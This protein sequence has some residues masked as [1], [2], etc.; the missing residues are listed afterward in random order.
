MNLIGTDY[1]FVPRKQLKIIFC[2]PG[3]SFSSN[4][5][6][7]WGELL[8]S[9]QKN[10]IDFQVSPAQDAV[11]YYVRNK[12]LGGEVRRGRNQKPFGGKID[13]DYLMWIDSDIVFRPED[14]YR[15]LKHGKDICAGLYM[16]DGGK[17]FAVVED[18]DT[19]FFKKNG[20]FRFMDADRAKK[21]NGLLEVDYSGF[22]WM[23]IKKGVFESLEY[24]WF[25][26]VFHTIG[27]CYDFS[28]EDVSFCKR[29]KE[30]G[31]KIHVDT[32]IRVGHEKKIIY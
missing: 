7:S 4:F 32:T 5:L 12:C 22:G 11:V 20:Y 18:W 31:Y 8:I 27:E 30:K 3:P 13:Y 14:F 6:M 21:V 19:E 17:N 1:K 9:L 24:P 15:L 28:S 2:L 25:Q 16:M 23:L 29:I 26:P 10:G